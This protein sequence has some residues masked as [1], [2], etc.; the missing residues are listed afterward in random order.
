MKNRPSPVRRPSERMKAR[1][2]DDGS[3]AASP[4]KARRR[5]EVKRP[6]SRP[7]GSTS[8]RRRWGPWRRRRRRGC[9]S[10]PS[11]GLPRPLPAPPPPRRRR[12]RRR[13]PGD[14]KPN[15]VAAFAG[16]QLGRALRRRLAGLL[17]SPVL[18]LIPAR[19]FTPI[20]GC[21]LLGFHRCDIQPIRSY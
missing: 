3:D 11:P 16:A 5:R 17:R 18:L 8:H 9:C 4:S 6:A 14:W 12:R 10:P 13:D 21:R 19:C 2:R 15:V 1:V 7:R 20:L